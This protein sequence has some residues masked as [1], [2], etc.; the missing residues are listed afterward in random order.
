MSFAQPNI[1]PCDA[2]PTPPHTHIAT[3]TSHTPHSQ[4]KPETEVQMDEATSRKL[5]VVVNEALLSGLVGL[6]ITGL[7]YRCR[8]RLYQERV[9]PP[10]GYV[11][12]LTTAWV[13]RGSCACAHLWARACRVPIAV[14]VRPG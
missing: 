13:L 1:G 8:R 7:A 10:S 14:V 4:A 3:H 9:K 5:M 12:A 6:L 2:T 11:H